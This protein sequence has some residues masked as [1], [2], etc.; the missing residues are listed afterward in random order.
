MRQPDRLIALDSSFKRRTP[1]RFFS[2]ALLRF[3]FSTAHQRDAP[4]G[5]RQLL[6]STRFRTISACC[7]L[8]VFDSTRWI[9]SRQAVSVCL[10][11]AAAAEHL[12]LRPLPAL[13]SAAATGTRVGVRAASVR[14]AG[15][16][17]TRVSSKCVRRRRSSRCISRRTR[18]SSWASRR[19]RRRRPPHR[20]GLVVRCRLRAHRLSHAAPLQPPR[21]RCPRARAR[22][23]HRHVEARSIRSSG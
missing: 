11:E 17:R 22:V 20:S 9:R 2:S 4:F 16:R 6:D 8:R 21:V 15:P 7:D 23:R 19:C 18:T 10:S 1:T 12:L 3:Q 13:K 14:P 5:A